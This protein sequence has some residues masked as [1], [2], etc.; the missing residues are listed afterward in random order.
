MRIRVLGTQPQTFA[1]GRE[2]GQQTTREGRQD[3]S[4]NGKQRAHARKVRGKATAETVAFN[5][6]RTQQEA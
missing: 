6:L 4:Q 1:H 5:S 2:S 3:A